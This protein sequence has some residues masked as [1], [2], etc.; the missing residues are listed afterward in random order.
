MVCAKAVP[1]LTYLVCQTPPRSGA[2][3]RTGYAP[4]P[5]DPQRYMWMV[6][7]RGLSAT[8]HRIRRKP[9]FL[10]AKIVARVGG[11]LRKGRLVRIG[12]MGAGVPPGPAYL[13]P[14]GRLKAAHA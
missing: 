7:R 1:S 14:A 13:P 3:V 10:T 9:N 4:V 6:L 12:H 5:P 8:D 2:T 11:L